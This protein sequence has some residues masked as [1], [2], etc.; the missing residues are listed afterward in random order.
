MK[1]SMKILDNPLP[2]NT[3][4]ILLN[5]QVTITLQ[6]RSFLLQK[7]KMQSRMSMPQI[8]TRSFLVSS[9]G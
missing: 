6:K 3:M 9:I 5:T 2:S 8:F 4:N 1:R 7:K